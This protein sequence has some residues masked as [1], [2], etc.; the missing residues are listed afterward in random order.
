MTFT[1]FRKLSGLGVLAVASLVLSATAVASD[2]AKVSFSESIR[3]ESKTTTESTFNGSSSQT[4]TVTQT[5]WSINGELALNDAV[6]KSIDGESLFRLMVGGF[7][8][9]G[10]LKDDP[11]FAAGKTSARLNIKENNSSGKS[12]TILVTVQLRWDKNK[13]IVKADAK[14]FNIKSIAADDFSGNLSGEIKA[15]TT[16]ILEFAGQA[17]HMTVPFEGKVNRKSGEGAGGGTTVSGYA[18]TVNI[19]GEARTQ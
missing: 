6:A 14:G 18:T 8:F 1:V 2:A 7:E 15:E 13:L 16:S 17:V 3:K 5:K 10:K 4:E 9:R 19:R 11:D 12:R